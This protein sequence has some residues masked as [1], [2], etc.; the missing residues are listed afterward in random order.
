MNDKNSLILQNDTERILAKIDDLKKQ[1]LTEK[2]RLAAKHFVRLFCELAE[3][4]FG[5]SSEQLKEFTKEE[6]TAL[7]GLILKKGKIRKIRVLLF[8]IS[9]IPVMFG[10]LCLM[11][12]FSFEGVNRNLSYSLCRKK[13]IK[14]RGQNFFP[15]EEFKKLLL[16]TDET[17]Y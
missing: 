2:E 6:L 7:D 10:I 4:Y 14:A 13:L 16:E 1:F 5:I 17:R 8:E 11:S 15:Y 12:D 3:Y 9:L